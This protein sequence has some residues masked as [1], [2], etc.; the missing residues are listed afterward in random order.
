MTLVLVLALVMLTLVLP[1]GAAP[2]TRRLAALLP[3]AEACAALTGAAV[4]LAGGTV[5]ALIGLFQVPFVASLEDLPLSRAAAAWPAAVPA[6]AVAGAVL[7]FQAV[8][9]VRRWYER[10]SLLAHTWASTRDAV[11]DGDQPFAY[12]A[13]SGFP[14][15]RRAGAGACGGARPGSG[16]RRRGR[17]G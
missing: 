4:L 16:R 9:V 15:S 17:L 3:P 11:S 12:P 10:R 6:A 13:V 8:L 1:W 2:A 7:A 5:A 14:R